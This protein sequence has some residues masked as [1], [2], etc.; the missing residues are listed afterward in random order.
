MLV[1]LITATAA[2]RVYSQHDRRTSGI[3]WGRCSAR[4]GVEA[5]RSQRDLDWIGFIDL[6]G[7]DRMGSAGMG[8]NEL[9]WN[10]LGW[11]GMDGWIRP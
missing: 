2:D 7:W 6:V 3:R 4:L 1:L 9:G 10:R 11:D 5:L 8:W